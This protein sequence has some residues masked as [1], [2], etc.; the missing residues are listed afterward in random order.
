[1]LIFNGQ[2]L[3]INAT[4]V[5]VDRDCSPCAKNT[6]RNNKHVNLKSGVPER[7]TMTIS[8]KLGIRCE[9]DR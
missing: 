1:M 3:K 7:D 5:L 2:P 6:S 4:I 9:I 8:T